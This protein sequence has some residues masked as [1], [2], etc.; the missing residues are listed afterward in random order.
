MVHQVARD[1]RGFV[2]T[3]GAQVLPALAG[4]T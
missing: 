2:K 3:F 4:A 1:Q